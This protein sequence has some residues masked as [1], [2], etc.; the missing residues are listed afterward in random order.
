V[1]GHVSVEVDPEL[2]HETEPT[3][4]EAREWVKRIDRPNL[5]VK[6]PAT[7]AG[8]P[9]M[10]ALI[11]EGISINVTLIFSL[12]R[13]RSDGRLPDRPRGVSGAGGDVSKVASV[14]SFFVSRVDSEVDKPGSKPSALTNCRGVAAAIANARAAYDE[15]LQKFRGAR[16]EALAANGAGSSARCGPRPAPRTPPTEPRC[17]STRW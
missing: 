3:V 7:R 15:F 1:D 14:A 5:L 12:E 10:R 9:A 2:A 16:W 6:V 8:I 17:T 4:A 13:Y 11:G